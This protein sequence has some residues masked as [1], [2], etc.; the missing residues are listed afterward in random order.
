MLLKTWPAPEF[1]CDVTKFIGFA[2]FYSRFIPN[3][4]MCV[5]TLHTVTKQ[6]YTDLIA[7]HWTPDAE[8]A[9]GDLK[10]AIL[11]D[12]CIQRFDYRNLVVLRTDFFQSRL[13]LHSI[14]ARK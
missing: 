12:P 8:Q 9:W 4:K 13:W 3:D 7:Q 14:T 6:E 2:Q 10:D 11:S 1:V 5:A